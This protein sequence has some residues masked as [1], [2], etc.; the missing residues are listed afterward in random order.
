MGGALAAAVTLMAR[1]RKAPH[2]CFQMLLYSVTDARQITE[3]IKEFT[4]TPP[5]N[6]RLNEKM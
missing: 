4:D 3:S 2:I 6:S 1:D 5:W